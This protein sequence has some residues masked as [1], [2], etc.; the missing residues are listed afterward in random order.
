M[1]GRSLWLSVALMFSSLLAVL[2]AI[3]ASGAIFGFIGD[4]KLL[5]AAALAL[6]VVVEGATDLLSV[7]WLAVLVLTLSWRWLGNRRWAIFVSATAG[8][9]FVAGMWVF[10]RLDSVDLSLWWRQGAPFTVPG[11]FLGVGAGV[12][13]VLAWTVATLYRLAGVL[14]PE[15]KAAAPVGAAVRDH[16]RRE[17]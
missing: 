13:I 4:F 12:G 11:I 5:T 7:G 17:A 10:A 3:L 1:M 16:D 9:V 2:T 8:L 14:R 6:A 15:C